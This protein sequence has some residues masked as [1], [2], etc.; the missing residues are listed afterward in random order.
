MTDDYKYIEI[1]DEMLPE[2]DDLPGCLPEIA[3]VIGVK[4]TLKLAQRFRGMPVYFHN[5]DPLARKLRDQG[6]RDS[7]DQMTQTMSG[8]ACIKILARKNGLST[9]QI[10]NIINAPAPAD[11][12]QLRLF[13]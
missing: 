6:I 7:Y 12:R 2:A 8:E 13:G 5:I 3:H 9:R 1:P 10:K 11:D 4:N